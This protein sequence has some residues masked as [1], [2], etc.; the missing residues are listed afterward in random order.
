MDDLGVFF[1][2]V[3][4]YTFCT[5]DVSSGDKSSKQE[6]KSYMFSDASLD[7]GIISF[8]FSISGI[9]SIS[10]EEELPLSS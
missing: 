1:F 9:S 3:C 8:G 10:V 6:S 5:T 7:P 4:F 2:K